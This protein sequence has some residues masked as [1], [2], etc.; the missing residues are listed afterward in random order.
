MKLFNSIWSI[1]VH[2]LLLIINIT[3]TFNHGINMTEEN[4]GLGMSTYLYTDLKV[5][6]RVPDFEFELQ[7][8]SLTMWVSLYFKKMSTLHFRLFPSLLKS[9]IN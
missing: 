3:E 4:F 7:T 2:S 8:T 1:L 5:L 6:V 9:E